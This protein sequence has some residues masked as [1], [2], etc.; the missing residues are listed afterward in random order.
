LKLSGQA[1]APEDTTVHV[2]S[3]CGTRTRDAGEPKEAAQVV[4]WIA[5]N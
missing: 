2:M 4:G 1:F 3:R 5:M